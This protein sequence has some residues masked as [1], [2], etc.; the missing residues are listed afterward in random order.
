MRGGDATRAA[1]KF[2]KW[3]LALV[4]TAP[5][6]LVADI[7]A[8]I[9]RFAYVALVLLSALRTGQAQVFVRERRR[10]LLAT[11]RSPTADERLDHARWGRA[12]AVASLG[13][14]VV[15]LVAVPSIGGEGIS[16]DA[17]VARLVVCLAL[18]SLWALLHGGTIYAA[19]KARMCTIRQFDAFMGAVRAVVPERVV[20]VVGAPGKMSRLVLVVC[21]MAGGAP[22]AGLTGQ[23]LGTAGQATT[24]PS[25]SVSPSAST[26]TTTWTSTTT[27]SRPPTPVPP[28]VPA[29]AEVCGFEPRARLR[30][31][32]P[33]SVGD[34][35]V[36]AWARV[37]AVE[38]GCPSD[39]PVLVG[40]LWVARLRGGQS[41]RAAVVATAEGAAAVVFAPLLSRLEAMLAAGTLAEVRPR[42]STGTGDF[43]VFLTVDGGCE[44]NQ[45][46]QYADDYVRLPGPAAAVVLRE[47][48]A[49]RAYPT[50]LERTGPGRF[51][52]GFGD[53]R[54]AVTDAAPAAGPLRPVV[55][56]YE[57]LAATGG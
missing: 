39:H 48:L 34:A 6:G 2:L 13:V 50:S 16:S 32:V 25:L 15:G 20:D 26:T 47:A 54:L 21:A 23:T 28:P 45:R 9:A 19:G 46:V 31:G 10:R 30:D 55:E 56:R 33:T 38:I 24:S 4:A 11:G 29:A 18:P 3:A 37:G 12:F 7:G 27:T 41:P 42:T 1:A 35:L 53:A 49:R 57:A 43:Q 36:E 22:A 14:A 40:T 52:V 5:I 17:F 51:E 44:V 8:S